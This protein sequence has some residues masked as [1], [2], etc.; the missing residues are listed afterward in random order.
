MSKASELRATQL[1]SPN[2]G[3]KHFLK[4]FERKGLPDLDLSAVKL[5]LNG[6]EPIS[7]ELC[8]EFLAALA[9]H[10][11]PSDGGGDWAIARRAAVHVSGAERVTVEGCLFER[12]DGN[13]GRGLRGP[14]PAPP[15]FLP[16]A[17]PPSP[18]L[19]CWCRPPLGLL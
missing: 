2:F 12:C 18:L 13:A 15:C 16:A 9:P 8:E 3:Y 4:L 5:I 17:R 7:Y 10:G 19:M 11:L 6:A 14:P 1:C